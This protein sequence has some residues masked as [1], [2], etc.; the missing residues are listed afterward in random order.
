MSRWN[1]AWLI[2]VP[3]IVVTGIVLSEAA[4]TKD[5]DKDYKLVKTIVDVLAEVDS[6][7]V[8]DLND[9]QKKKLVEDMINGGL[10]R[11]DR[12]SAYMNNDDLK[13]F[14]TQTEGNFFGV[15]IQ[16]GSD[17]KTGML[18]V[19]SPMVGTP[20]YEAGILAGDI[21]TKIEDKSTENMRLGEAVKMIQ[22]KEGTQR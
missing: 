7:Y 3:M 11:L 21:I 2:A 22:G 19:V 6:H 17:P 8:R 5:R 10:E 13:Q 4:P 15:G 16:L 20:A 1:L 9:E 14:E 12:Y 18:M